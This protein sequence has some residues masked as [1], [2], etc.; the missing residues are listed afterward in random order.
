ME[1]SRGR[2]FGK[3]YAKTRLRLPPRLW[4]IWPHMQ[5]G[6]TGRIEG[7]TPSTIV[8]SFKSTFLTLPYEIHHKGIIVTS[9]LKRVCLTAVILR[10]CLASTVC[11]RHANSFVKRHLEPQCSQARSTHIIWTGMFR[12]IEGYRR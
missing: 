5:Q 3:T 6:S 4:R 11:P 8:L 12:S 7:S 1:S 2:G 10:P 9:L